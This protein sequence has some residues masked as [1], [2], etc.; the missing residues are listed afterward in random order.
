[1]N[2]SQQT[3]VSRQ[4]SRPIIIVE[5]NNLALDKLLH[6]ISKSGIDVRKALKFQDIGNA[7]TDLKSLVQTTMDVD[8][9]VTDIYHNDETNVFGLIRA[10][11]QVPRLWNTPLA[12]YTNDTSLK[13]INQLRR[14]VVHIPFRII[15][16]N[17]PQEV[18]A[19]I[20]R[21][22]LDYKVQNQIYLDVELKTQTI[23][24]KN[25]TSMMPLGLEMI[26]DYANKY[27]KICTKS[28]MAL[29]RGK[30]YFGFLKNQRKLLGPLLEKSQN[31]SPDD[32]SY[33]QLMKEIDGVSKNIEEMKNLAEKNFLDAHESNPCDWKILHTTYEY[34]MG[35]RNFAQAKKYLGTLTELFPDSW[36]FFYN[37]GKIQEMESDFTKA[38][39]SYFEGMRKA[40]DDGMSNMNLDDLMDM[41]D[42]SLLMTKRIFERIGV[43]SLEQSETEDITSRKSEV[44]RILR[45]SNAQV[46]SILLY[47]SEKSPLNADCFNK[48][49]ITYRRAGDFS[50]ATDSY[51]KALLLDPKNARIRM[52]LSVV[53]ALCNCWDKATD[54]MNKVK[55]LDIEAEDEK[56]IAKLDQIY[57][58][59]QKEELLKVLI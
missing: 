59:K 3:G 48:I 1:M 8:L 11:E 40:L 41:V 37:M 38:F 45:K 55:R 16:K 58:N 5:R 49:G 27:P 12:I 19:K 28:K 9:V 47:I 42:R 20:I 22:M 30:L 4:V 57:I 29:L 33:D 44:M 13:T 17:S 7:L 14:E 31:I 36:D 32:A 52:N 56:V 39:Q 23:I 25:Y 24:D 6:G 51:S 53:L 35:E 50:N 26:D 46:R 18:T 2:N 43:G 54:E 34:Y 15:A 10:M 21:E